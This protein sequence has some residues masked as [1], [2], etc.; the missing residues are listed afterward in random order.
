MNTDY[1]AHIAKQKRERLEKLTLTI[2]NGFM[3]NSSLKPEVDN[4]YLV[5]HS[6]EV[7]KELIK[8]LDEE[9]L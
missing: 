1:K 3:S 5:K 8:Q 2:L 6:I 7:A 9:E 4:E